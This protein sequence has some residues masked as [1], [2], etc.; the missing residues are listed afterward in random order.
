M[1][2]T[3][4]LRAMLSEALALLAVDI[5]DE[6][7]RHAGHA[8]TRPGGE[9]HFRVRIVAAAFEGK[10]RLERHRMVNILLEEEFTQGLHA[11][12][13]TTLTPAEDLAASVRHTCV[14]N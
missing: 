14:F 2:V 6:S 4:R 9:S 7:A 8:H 1:P 3:D 11:M 12:A 5:V 13:L 10:S